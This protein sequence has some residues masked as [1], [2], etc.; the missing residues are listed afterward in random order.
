M[1]SIAQD[2][3]GKQAGKLQLAGHNAGQKGRGV[4]HNNHTGRERGREGRSGFIC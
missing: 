2:G 4:L 1:A 3:S